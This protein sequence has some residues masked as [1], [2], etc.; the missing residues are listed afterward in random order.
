MKP[1]QETYDFVCTKLL[2]QGRPS[3]NRSGACLYRSEDGAKCAAGWCIPDEKYDPEMDLMD[4]TG[5]A[6][7]VRRF[8]GDVFDGHDLG[9]LSWL[10]NAHDGASNDRDFRLAFSTRARETAKQFALNAK[11]LDQQHGDSK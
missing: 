8:G 5:V 1:L 11:V 4:E 9:L 2:E 3:K 7:I 6:K 10:Q